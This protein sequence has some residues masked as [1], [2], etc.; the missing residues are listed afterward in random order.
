[1]FLFVF[2][3]DSGRSSDSSS[4]TS[5]DN[6]KVLESPGHNRYQGTSLPIST[7]TPII[8]KKPLQEI[9]TQSCRSE[10]NNALYLFLKHAWLHSWHEIS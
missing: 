10:F 7:S 9:N 8:D 3:Q 2:W 4:R 6:H 5:L 1:M